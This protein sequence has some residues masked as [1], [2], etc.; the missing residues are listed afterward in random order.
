MDKFFYQCI[1]IKMI[2]KQYKNNKTV[3]AIN[4]NNGKCYYLPL[5]PQNY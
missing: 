2:D 3:F 5:T 1:I 4:L